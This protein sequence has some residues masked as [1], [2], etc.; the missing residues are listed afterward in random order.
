VDGTRGHHVK[1]NKSDRER[2]VSHV[3][4]HKWNLVRKN[5][6]Q[7]C[8]CNYFWKSVFKFYTLENSNAITFIVWYNY[9]NIFYF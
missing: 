9:R 4:S 5:E 1:W 6:W 8:D 3:L 7:E 2:Q